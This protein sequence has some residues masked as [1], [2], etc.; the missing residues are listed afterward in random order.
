MAGLRICVP[1][2]ALLPGSLEALERAGVDVEPL[3]DAGRRLIVQSPSGTTFITTRPSDVPTYVEAGAADIGI[4]GKDVL[5]ERDPDVPKIA[6]VES[7]HRL[8]QVVK[9]DT[10]KSDPG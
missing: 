6:P 8:V 4:V 9:S 5:Y 1:L 3:R 10:E 2:G 7:N